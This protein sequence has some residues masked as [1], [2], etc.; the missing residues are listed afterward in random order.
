M[1][2]K[3]LLESEAGV[4]KTDLAGPRRKRWRD[5]NKTAY[6]AKITAGEANEP[7]STNTGF[8]RF[9]PRLKARFCDD[10]PYIIVGKRN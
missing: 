4:A 10:D 2:P 3:A 8:G 7:A 1:T 5:K 9:L 6:R